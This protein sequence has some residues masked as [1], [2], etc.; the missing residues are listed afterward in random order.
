MSRA[1]PVFTAADWGYRG[2]LRVMLASLDKHSHGPIR[3]QVRVLTTTESL[4]GFL[5][6]KPVDYDWLDVSFVP[7]ELTFATGLPVHGHTGIMTYAR[8]LLESRDLCPWDR[9]LYLDADILVRRDIEPLMAAVRAQAAAIAGVRECRTQNVAGIGGVFNWREMGL[10]AGR[11]Y[12]NAGILGLRM[13][14]VRRTEIF[15]RAIDYLKTHGQQVVSWDQ[16]AINAVTNTDLALWPEQFN[17]TTSYQGRTARKSVE[18]LLERKCC[19]NQ[20]AIIAHFTGS[21]AAKPWH[22]N[23]Q[24]PFRSEYKVYMDQLPDISF[25]STNT[26]L[27]ARFGITLAGYIRKALAAVNHLP[28]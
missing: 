5:R 26:R 20:D 10:D 7:L 2:P 22:I 21:G 24:S 6:E 17:Y 8:L 19:S 12:I 15:R 13:D 25:P 1:V 16:G 27:E 18:R 9:I 23:S 4:R 14:V 3:Q 28:S 11:A